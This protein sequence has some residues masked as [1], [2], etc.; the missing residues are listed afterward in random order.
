MCLF[1]VTYV[2]IEPFNISISL[3]IGQLFDRW[4]SRFFL[5]LACLFKN[6]E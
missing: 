2:A 3:M 1:D 6:L 4:F 5:K